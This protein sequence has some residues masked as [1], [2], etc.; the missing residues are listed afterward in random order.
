MQVY[1]NDAPAVRA[2]MQEN[3]A[4]AKPIHPDLPYA[5]AE[6]IWAVRHELART[7]ED[8]LARRTRAI[9]LNARASIEAAQHV[10]ELIAGELQYD[11]DWISDQI[12]AYTAFAQTY[13]LQPTT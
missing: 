4:W 2:L 10:A 12:T 11:N 9:L 7:V 5:S 13:L 3:P 8:V 1:G 6:V